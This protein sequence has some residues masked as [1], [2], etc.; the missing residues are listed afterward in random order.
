MAAWKLG[1]AL[2]CGNTVVLK[3]AE[4]TPLSILYFA[5][6]IKEAGFPPGVVNILNGHGRIAGAAIA[7]HLGI[8]KIAFTG[9]TATGKEVMKMA[10]VNMKNITLETGGKS[11]LIVFE[12]LSP[13]TEKY[14]R[15]EK[16]ARYTR[17][18]TL[19]VYMLV[20][21]VEQH[22]EVYRRSMGWK[23]ER[24]SAGQTVKL[25]QLDLELPVGSIYEG[26]L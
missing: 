24:F 13:S 7:K 5:N 19:E 2:A 11:P 14:D 4:Q 15:T 16:F 12:V 25:E 18:P 6:L 3:A 9:S 10:S 8:D 21:Q 26:V 23:Q 17:C 20:S 22:I 1:P